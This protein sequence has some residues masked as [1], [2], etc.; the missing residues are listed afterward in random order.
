MKSLK[1]NLE[2]AEVEKKKVKRKKKADAEKMSTPQMYVSLLL[3]LCMS[4]CV[5]LFSCKTLTVLY[6]S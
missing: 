6:R 5:S 4:I 2:I 1:D 3:S